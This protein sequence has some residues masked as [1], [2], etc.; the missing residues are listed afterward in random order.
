[1]QNSYMEGRG[2]GTIKWHRLSQ[3]PRGAKQ[4]PQQMTT[5][6]ESWKISSGIARFLW[7]CRLNSREKA[8]SLRL[9]GR[10]V[11]CNKSGLSAQSFIIHQATD[12]NTMR[13]AMKKKNIYKQRSAGRVKEIKQ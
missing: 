8:K 12:G 13:H 7:P 1:M 4:K 9:K 11:D 5:V 10:L 6:I 2:S 3:S